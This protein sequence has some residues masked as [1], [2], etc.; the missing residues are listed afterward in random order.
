M[1][2]GGLPT[3]IKIVR[4]KFNNDL[5]KPNRLL[6]ALFRQRRVIV[7]INKA[8]YLYFR[9]LKHRIILAERKGSAVQQYEMLTKLNA[10]EIINISSGFIQEFIYLNTILVELLG[11]LDKDVTRY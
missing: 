11:Y 10:D 6:V 1:K 3:L 8:N 4:R 2:A 9:R 5:I 7:Q